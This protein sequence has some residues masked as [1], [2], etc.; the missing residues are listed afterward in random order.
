[1]VFGFQVLTTGL[2]Y[3]TKYTLCNGWWTTIEADSCLSTKPMSVI[4]W[5]LHVLTDGRH[6]SNPMVTWPKTIRKPLKELVPHKIN[7]TIVSFQ[8]IYY[9]ISISLSLCFS[10][11]CDF[12]FAAM[13]QIQHSQFLQCLFQLSLSRGRQNISSIDLMS[14]IFG[15]SLTIMILLL[16]REQFVEIF[17]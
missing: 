14:L 2:S 6:S 15:F 7:L 1:M 10:V 16:D 4:V 17:L 3:C 8:R 5:I 12:E 13:I 11:N 9:C